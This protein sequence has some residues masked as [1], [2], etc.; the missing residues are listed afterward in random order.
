MKDW[1][2]QHFS[3]DYCWQFMQAL[4]GRAAPL[5]VDMFLIVNPPAWFDNIWK[6]MKPMLSGPFRRKVQMIQQEKLGDFL[7][8]GFERYLPDE[9]AGGYCPVPQLIEDFMAL[10][11]YTEETSLERRV[12]GSS[13]WEWPTKAISTSE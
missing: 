13:G 8:P 3:V 1:T 10:R 5:N 7:E 12:S 6:I 4:Q 9:M 2:M 11:S